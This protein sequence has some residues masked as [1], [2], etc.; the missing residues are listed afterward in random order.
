[1]TY[2]RSLGR[3]LKPDGRVAILDFHPHGFVSGL[4][5]H[6][7]AKEEVRREMESAGYLLS[8]N[9][10]LIDGQHFQI[11]SLKD[12]ESLTGLRKTI[13]K[14]FRLARVGPLIQPDVGRRGPRIESRDPESQSRGG[15]ERA[16]GANDELSPSGGPD[17]T[18]RHDEQ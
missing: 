3:Y 13:R 2:F 12:S 10:D 14:P 8:A 9:F 4:L 18:E 5:G 7:T 1:V 11:F 17:G 16:E 6:G 15:G